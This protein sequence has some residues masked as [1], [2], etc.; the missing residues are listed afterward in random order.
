MHSTQRPHATRSRPAS[1]LAGALLLAVAT[2]SFLLV[3]FPSEQALAVQPAFPRIAIWWPDSDNQPVASRARCD[4]TALHGTDADH[5]AELRAANPDITILGTTSAR[6]LDYD[7]DKYDSV[8]NVELRSAS[9]D[10]ILTQ[11]GT[12]LASD[13]TASATSIPVADA[14]KFVAGDMVLVDHE[15]IHVVSVG[16]SSLTVTRGQVDPTA[17]HASGARIAPVVSNW[18]GSVTMD[19]STNC[20]KRDVGYGLETW[21]DWNVRRGR[22][23]LASADW[24][25]LLVDVLEGDPSWMVTVG[26]SGTI[27]EDRDNAADDPTTLD[28]AW[29]AGAEAYG[30]ALKAAAGGRIVI[31]NGN[32]RNYTLNG[33]VFET[34]P[35]VGLAPATWTDIFVGSYAYPRASYRDW[36]AN[37]AG[38]NLTTIQTYGAANDYRL[39]RFGLTSALMNDGYFSYALS[40]RGHAA[41]GLYWFDEYDDAGAGRGYLGQPT[42]AATAV[43]DAYRRDYAGGVALVNPSTRSVTVELGGAFLKI[44]GTQDPKVNDGSV[45]TAVTIPAQDGIVLLRIGAP[46]LWA[47]TT[48]LTYGRE[49]TLRVAVGPVPAAAVSIEQRPAG[50]ASWGSVATM[51][52]DAEGAAFLDLAPPVTTEYRLVLVDTGDISNIVKVGVRRDATVIASRKTVPRT[53]RVVFSGRVRPAGRVAVTLERSTGGAWKTLRRLTTSSSGRYT[54]KVS[55]RR[56]GS[57]SCRIRV[58][59]DSRHLATT[60]RT[61]RIRVR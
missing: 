42:G 17:S 55:F 23:V 37:A 34:F 20:P 52:T 16:T 19:L 5:I 48:A 30:D 6:E 28:A 39:M 14:T 32:M 21:S 3:A 35:Y 9:T 50:S 4:W 38:P 40:D 61:V 18:P 11:V 27:D 53:G 45:V 25:G 8:R 31:G 56:R 58:R 12:T 49:T 57:V 33:T 54:F 15:L 7:L 10:W 24:D 22:T 46:V 44:K 60:S 13:I 29:N 43:G 36:M 51:T 41:S 1:L 59:A 2:L 47:S 26:N